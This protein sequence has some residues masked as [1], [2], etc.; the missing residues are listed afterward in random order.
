MKKKIQIAI[1]FI[2][3]LISFDSYTQD[4]EVAPIRLEFSVEPGENQTKTLNIKNHGNKK[5]SFIITIADFIPG[6]DGTRQTMPPSTTRRS[7]ATWININPSFFELNPGDHI[8]VQVT[9]LVPGDE[10]GASW[11]MLHVQPT[12][13]QTTWD[14]DKALGAGVMVGGRIGVVVHQSPSSNRNHAIKVTSIQEITSEE[15]QNRRFSATLDNLGDKITNCK[16]HLIASN[17]TTAEEVQ[18]PSIDVET[19][20]KMTRNVEVELPI[21]KLLPG[22]YALAIIVDYGPRFSLEGAQIIIDVE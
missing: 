9:M 7:A 2:A 10:Y 19:F 3:L 17:I 11:C 6:S 22:K 14:V 20:P 13:E 4:F 15:N 16:V 21:G 8:S 5:S 1:V 12:I 18:F